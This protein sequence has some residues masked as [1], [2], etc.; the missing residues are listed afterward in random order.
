MTQAGDL[1]QI[2]NQAR[3]LYR[4]RVNVCFQAVSS[5]NEGPNAPTATY[6]HML[7]AD[8]N[9]GF[10]KQRNTS[11]TAW[12]IVG[13]LDDPWTWT[14]VELPPNELTTGDLKL[15]LK[16]T[17]DSGWVMVNDRTIGDAAS[18]STERAHS[19]CEPLFNLIW[20]NIAEMWAPTQTSSG[21]TTPRGVSA[22]ADWAAHRRL[23][24]SKALG[25]SIGLAGSGIGISHRMLGEAAGEESHTLTQAEMFHTHGIPMH[26][27]GLGPA[28]GIFTPDGQ[29]DGPIPTPQPFS[30]IDPTW[31][32]N[33]MAK[34]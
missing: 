3:T 4:G 14:N 32:V 27:R 1:G 5:F 13:K 34:L 21:S 16:T 24:M 10:V 8:N 17:A 7:W 23:V 33:V 25:R 6:P 31:F 15:T 26:N 28:G 9:S 18:N 2:A 30:L 19:D 20:N 29:T 11:N 12:H 22:A